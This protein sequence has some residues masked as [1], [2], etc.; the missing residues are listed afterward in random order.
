MT[1]ARTL[2]PAGIFCPVSALPSR[3]GI[4]DFGPAAYRFI[5]WLA[6]AGQRYW[7]VLPLTIPDSVGSPYAPASSLAGNWLLISLESLADEGLLPSKLRPHGKL[8]SG[9]VVYRT[10]Y[11]KKLAVL[12]QS[13]NYFLRFGDPQLQRSWRA[14]V[15]REHFWLDD[16]AWFLA[17]KDRYRHQAW[18][19]WPVND[20]TRQTANLNDA[21]LSQRYDFQTYL[22]WVFDRQWSAV[23]RAA[24][25]RGLRIIGD[26]PFGPPLD[27]AEVWSRPE[28]FM[29]D[30]RHRPKMVGGVPPDAFTGRGQRWGNPVY[31]WSAHRADRYQW[32]TERLH[33][34]LE[35]YDTI[36]FDHFRGLAA[37]WHIPANQSNPRH[38]RWVASPG[39]E[40]LRR[41][42]RSTRSLPL[43]AEDLGHFSPNAEHLRRAFRID[44]M[45][46]LL[47]A[48]SGLP[49]N[50]HHPDFLQ[51]DM[52]YY[53]STHDTNTVQGWWRD[54]A[55]WY[56]R[57]HA[58]NRFGTAKQIHWQFIDQVYQSRA[59]VAMI[60]LQDVFGLGSS[61]RL[62]RPGVKRGNWGWRFA[63]KLLTA[64]SA[65]RLGKLAEKYGG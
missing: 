28:L 40:I 57:M 48:W 25:Q 26:M 32:W 17:L 30:R 29:L 7:Q 41:L 56:E 52:Y 63:T 11:R 65:A 62:N 42:V 51:S 59:D 33:V 60:P 64:P 36:R 18:W 53:T 2:R 1:K 27:S 37:T 3:S 50:I 38:G 49:H 55:K 24:H 4:G 23:R 47:F 6:A 39:R 8:T 61:S 14:F 19:R 58:R 21:K 12:R 54:E 5:D 10:V 13:Y 44:G 20:Q 34:A 46:V 31:R 35:R 43:M 15:R 9:R 45:R 22:Q 16:A